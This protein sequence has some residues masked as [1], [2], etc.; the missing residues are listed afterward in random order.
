MKFYKKKINKYNRKIKKKID[1]KKQSYKPLKI[2]NFDQMKNQLTYI[3][4]EQFFITVGIIF[5]QMKEGFITA[6]YKIKMK[7]NIKSKKKKKMNMN[8]LKNKI[9]K[10]KNKKFKH[11][12]TVL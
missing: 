9:K 3:N 2:K 8:K 12:N 1:Y 4:F 7:L 6:I 5:K 10:N 11:L